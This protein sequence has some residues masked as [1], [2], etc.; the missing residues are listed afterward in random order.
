M[1]P[2]PTMTF[3][4][5]W[6]VFDEKTDAYVFEALNAFPEPF[7]PDGTPYAFPTWTRLVYGGGGLWKSEEDVYNPARDSGRVFKAW[8]QAGG[9]TR[10]GERVRWC[11]AREARGGD[12][13][14]RLTEAKPGRAHC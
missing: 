6:E 10:S 7:Q 14:R 11:T 2:F 9:K 13:L 8:I 5:T 3:P 12:R 4:Y 1:A